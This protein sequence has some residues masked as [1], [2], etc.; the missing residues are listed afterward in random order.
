MSYEEFY[1]DDANRLW[2]GVYTCYACSLICI[3][4]CIANFLSF[5][6]Q[7]LFLFKGSVLLLNTKS[8]IL[9]KHTVKIM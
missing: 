3:K 9:L 2:N 6:N 4:T 8:S 1:T 5:I 7:H